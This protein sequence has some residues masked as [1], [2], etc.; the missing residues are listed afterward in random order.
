MAVKPV[1]AVNIGTPPLVA[2]RGTVNHT[3]LKLVP[4]ASTG[5]FRPAVEQGTARL[6]LQPR[7]PLGPGA[8]LL[9]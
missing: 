4:R 2:E 9:N 5:M 6:Q 7:P 1:P 8:A 3:K